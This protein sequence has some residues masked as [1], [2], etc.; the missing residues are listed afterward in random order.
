MLRGGLLHIHLCV[1]LLM[2]GIQRYTDIYGG[3]SLL[4]FYVV[5]VVERGSS[6]YPFL[7]PSPVELYL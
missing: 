5:V 2:N 1:Y 3:I 7:Y 6:P 4:T